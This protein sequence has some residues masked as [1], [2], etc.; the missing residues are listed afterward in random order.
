MNSDLNSLT[1][2]F[3]V[4][5]NEKL[6][7]IVNLSTVFSFWCTCSNSFIIELTL[8][9]NR[10]HFFLFLA[11]IG[12]KTFRF[13]LRNFFSDIA[14]A[15]EFLSYFMSKTKDSSTKNEVLEKTSEYRFNIFS[16]ANI[17][18]DINLGIHPN[19]TLRWFWWAFRLV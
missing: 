11:W 8:F 14:R 16:L 15:S 13:F 5:G 10:E 17:K 4:I 2:N 7:K 1:Y 3:F 18:V 6:K 9:K 12:K 19:K